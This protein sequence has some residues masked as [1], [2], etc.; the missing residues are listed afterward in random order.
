MR[1]YLVSTSFALLTAVAIVSVGCGEAG[2]S[3]TNSVE[4]ELHEAPPAACNS[5]TAHNVKNAQECY[6]SSCET[7]DD[8]CKALTANF[9]KFQACAL[10]TQGPPPHEFNGL[11]GGN[12]WVSNEG[13]LKHIGEVFCTALCSCGLTTPVQRVCQPYGFACE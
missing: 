8:V 13:Q 1:I 9:K 6:R 10:E 2:G 4:V 7:G 12:A 5:I 3:D 11:P